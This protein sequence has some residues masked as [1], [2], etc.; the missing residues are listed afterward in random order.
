[1]HAKEPAALHASI[2][3]DLAPKSAG[4]SFQQLLAHA[5]MQQAA[6]RAS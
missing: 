3:Q 6:R 5:E 2:L 1:V 4:S